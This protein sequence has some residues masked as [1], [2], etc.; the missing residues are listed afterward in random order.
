MSDD[1]KNIQIPTLN[2]FLALN[3]VSKLSLSALNNP[4][5]LLIFQSILKQNKKI[6]YITPNEQNALKFQKDLENFCEIE[7]KIFPSQEINFYDDVEK[8][9]YIYQEQI[10]VLLGSYDVVLAPIRSL[11]EKFAT[12]NFYEK[13]SF[14]IKVNED[15]DYQKLI[16]S[17]SKLGYRR[18]TGVVDTSE[19]SVR[20]DI[21]DIYTLDKNPVRIEFFGDNVE[22]I[23][24]FDPKTQR[25]YEK[26]NEITI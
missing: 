4:L 6:L 17:L 12:R 22:D 13:N 14:K 8:N 21:L 26:V 11:F 20:G 25:S 1:L 16:K 2:R 15:V 3:G 9:Y 10:N 5:R 7:A 19:F 23:R 24:Y 18:T